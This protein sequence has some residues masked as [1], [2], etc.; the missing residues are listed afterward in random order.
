MHVAVK[1]A[2]EMNLNEGYRIVIN[3]GKQGGNK[4]MNT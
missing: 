3:D 4:I 2:K 1:V